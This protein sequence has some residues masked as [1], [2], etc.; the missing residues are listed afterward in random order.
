MAR[1]CGIPGNPH[2][3][4]SNNGTCFKCGQAVAGESFLKAE[5][6]STE[7]PSEET[8]EASEDSDATTEDKPKRT[9]RTRAQVDS[10]SG[11]SEQ[12][13]NE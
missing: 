6:E 2:V 1:D 12:P 11:D 13:E 9:R 7:E 5:P 3:A 8:S 4:V 10:D